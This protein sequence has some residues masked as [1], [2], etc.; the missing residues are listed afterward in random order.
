VTVFGQGVN[1]CETLEGVEL[2]RSDSITWRINGERLMLLGWGRAILM[3]FAHPLV[4][5]A[6]ADHSSFRAGRIARLQ[7]L[8]STVRAMLAL[9]FGDRAHVERAAMHINRIHD[10]IHGTLAAAVGPFPQGTPYSAHDPRL[11]CW[12]LA[13]LM[14]SVPMA[15]EQFIGPLSAAEH[16]RYCEEAR[17]FGEMLGIPE[18]MIPRT[19]AD[20][21]AFVQDQLAG[22]EIVVSDLARMLARDIL[23]PPFQPAYWPLARLIRL[24]TAGTLDPRLREGYGL[25]WSARD[26]R[27][28]ARWA[29]VVRSVRAAA[30]TFA[31]RWRV[32]R[33]LETTRTS[34]T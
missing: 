16:A 34:S 20:V 33:M 5:Q 28:L 25:T 15:Y 32:A 7:R 22:G 11:L 29:G 26:E 3:Q 4:A 18:S 30:P 10:R 2:P 8:Q 27:T 1:N 24:T 19:P 12:V 9:T 31:A 21:R 17:G 14:E 23:Y 6:V 13:T